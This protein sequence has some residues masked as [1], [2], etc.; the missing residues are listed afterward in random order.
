ME[1]GD[2]HP[3]PGCVTIH[4]APGITLALCSGREDQISHGKARLF[5]AFTSGV[6]WGGGQD[7]GILET[8]QQQEPPPPPQ[9]V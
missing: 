2:P 6:Q 3:C 1:A 5:L 7:A 9:A 4:C 8:L